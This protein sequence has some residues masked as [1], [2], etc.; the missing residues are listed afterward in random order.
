MPSP[1][2]F[3][4][5]TDDQKEIKV[6]WKR[7]L[8]RIRRPAALLLCLLVVAAVIATG[9]SAAGGGLV[10]TFSVQFPKGHAASN[11]PCP[12]DAFCGVGVLARYGAATIT[13]L[14]ESFEPL[15]DSECFA[16]TRTERIDLLS[17]AGGLILESRGTFC[18]PGGSGAS[19]A[20]PSSYGQPGTF[21]L[22]YTLDGADST[23]I[24]AGAA[25][26]GLETMTVAGGIGVWNLA[27]SLATT[28]GV[29]MSGER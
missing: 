27:G 8:G 15:P 11:A 19:K 21:T 29:A 4:D 2:H 28:N 23:G 13:I 7:N 24:F 6:H 22:S 20:S 17:G 1:S 25:G 10:G 9:A 18:R 14:D 3:V 26:S 16:V 12:P 5:R